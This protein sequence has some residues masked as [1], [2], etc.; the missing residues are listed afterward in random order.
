LIPSKEKSNNQCRINACNTTN[1]IG[2]VKHNP[3]FLILVCERRMSCG[4]IT[5]GMMY[6]VLASKN[7]IDKNG[8]KEKQQQTIIQHK[9]NINNKNKGC[10][11]SD[12][13]KSDDR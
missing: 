4:S 3:I 8:S 12:A 7:F 10:F 11:N 1:N 13:G 2:I 5:N 6:Q 9:C